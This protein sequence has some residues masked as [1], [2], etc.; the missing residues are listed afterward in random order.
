VGHGGVRH[1]RYSWQGA[2][3]RMVPRTPA[4]TA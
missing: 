3:L 2:G 1:A 4:C